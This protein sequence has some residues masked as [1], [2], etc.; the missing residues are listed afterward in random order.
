MK[1]VMAQSG[2]E[3]AWRET[4]STKESFSV[5]GTGETTPHVMLLLDDWSLEST[6]YR[7]KVQGQRSPP[8]DHNGAASYPATMG[9]S[10]V[11]VPEFDQARVL[12]NRL[13]AAA[14][15]VMLRRTEYVLKV[16][17]SQKCKS[18]D[19]C[20]DVFR[21]RGS[22]LP[23]SLDQQWKIST[24]TGLPTT[25]RYQTTTVGHV[26]GPVW[27]EVYF[28]QFAT[29]EGLVVPAMIGANL[30]GQRQVWTLVSFKKNPGFDISQ[31]D[32]EVAQ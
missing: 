2:G 31:F 10:Q 14:A 18:G 13:P 30:R 32:Q 22:S 12:V 5:L 11:P 21:T 8:T 9:T 23:P 24:S 20:V 26:T 17:N 6:R 7:R 16:S 25:I 1:N 4:R 29:K 3:A 28:L 27:R 19:I 15:E